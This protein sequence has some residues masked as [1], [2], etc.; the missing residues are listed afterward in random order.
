[1]KIVLQYYLISNPDEVFITVLS[2]LQYSL[3]NAWN[4]STDY[5]SN[6]LVYKFH[7]NDILNALSPADLLSEDYIC[8]HQICCKEIKQTIVFA[9][10]TAKT[11]YNVS[12]KSVSSTEKSMIYLW[13]F[14]DYI[15]SD[16]INQ[17]LLNQQIEL[18]YVI[19]CINQPVYCLELLFTMYIHFI[20]S[21]AQL[22]S[23]LHESDLYN[24]QINVNL[25]FIENKDSTANKDI[26]MISAYKI[27]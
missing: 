19:K 11:Y 18:F 8:I 17:K 10:A 21:I 5:A 14:H 4:T 20:M 9:N 27:E 15:I 13:L 23:T 26:E 24:H 16:L 12:H 1:M 25:L 7:T 3:N 22:K 6:E 2:Y